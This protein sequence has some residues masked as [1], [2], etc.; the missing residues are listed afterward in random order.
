[1]NCELRIPELASLTAFFISKGR[2]H[3]AHFQFKIYDSKFEELVPYG[4][5]STS[6]PSF[7]TGIRSDRLTPSITTAVLA[8]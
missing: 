3:S 5:A 2:A 6:A 7:F 1:M 4:F 8:T